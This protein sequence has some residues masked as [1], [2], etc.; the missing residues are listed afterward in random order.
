MLTA[1]FTW[2]MD[3]LAIIA[4]IIFIVLLILFPIIGLLAGWKR[5]AFWGGGNFLFFV[6]GLI[7]LFNKIL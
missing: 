2:P 6:I 7:I 1:S 3:S 4:P 5:A